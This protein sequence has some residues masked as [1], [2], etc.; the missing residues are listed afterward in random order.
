MKEELTMSTIEQLREQIEHT[1]ADIIKK[2]AKRQKLAKQIG[3]LKSEQGK[4]VVD[5]LREKILFEFYEELSAKHNLQQTF[6]KRLFK[7][8]ISYS[9]KVQKS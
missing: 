8:I 3:Q 4:D 6:V 9:K 2:L 7:L 1:D 5:L